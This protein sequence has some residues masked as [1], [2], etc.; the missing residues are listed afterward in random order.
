MT[1][2]SYP[3]FVLVLMILVIGLALMMNGSVGTPYRQIAYLL[4]SLP[5]VL[6][7]GVAIR[8]PATRRAVGVALTLIGA[9]AGLIALQTVPLPDATLAHPVWS[10]LAQAG[11]AA[12]QYISVAPAQTRESLPA[13]ILPVLVFAAML[14]LCQRREDAL[15]AWKLLAVIGLLL[16]A[17][18]VVLEL[19][20]E[21][22][23]FFAESRIGRGSFSGI[24]VNRN[25]TASLA[26]MTALFLGGWLFMADSPA[27]RVQGARAAVARP[28]SV[29]QAVL[30]ALLFLVLIV[31]M[32]TGSRAG[33]AFGLTALTL[34]IAVHFMLRELSAA[35]AGKARAAPY[36]AAL[37]VLGGLAVFGLFGGPVLM[38]MEA[39]GLDVQR[40][41]AWHGTWQSILERPLTGSGFGTFAEVFPR[42]RD[43]DCLG[44]GGWW[45]RAHNGYL[46]FVAGTGLIGLG[47]A[48]VMLALLAGTLLT[49]ISR[50]RALRPL[51]VFSA[52]GLV[53]VLLHTAFDFPLQIPGMSFYFAAMMGVGCALS[54]RERRAAPRRRSGRAAKQVMS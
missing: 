26:G 29:R 28:I 7:L 8:A 33:A 39:R 9:L 44:T 18:S 20:F 43:P 37:A 21:D 45:D 10:E 22:A 38:R 46:E 35:R 32:V 47:I 1:R 31:M 19:F 17:L 41:C 6:T 48:S 23:T 34:S 2:L 40:W 27:T 54:L 4:L 42:F 15:L 30:T 53:F 12:G 24:M 13:L 50:R 14:I 11:I 49:G 52:G 51:V 5:M 25:I 3:R 16:M 36:K